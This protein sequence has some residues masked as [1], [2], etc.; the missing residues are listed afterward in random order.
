[1]AME[2]IEINMLLK[3]KEK[4]ILSTW[5]ISLRADTWKMNGNIYIIYIS[6]QNVHR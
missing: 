3:E 4:E 5:E 2:I 1:M 6:P